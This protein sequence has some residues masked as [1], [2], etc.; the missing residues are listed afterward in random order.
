MMSFTEQRARGRLL[1]EFHA[2]LAQLRGFGQR[3][4]WRR[5]EQILQRSLL[6]GPDAAEFR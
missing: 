4:T 2:D 6:M 5:A 1:A 3:G